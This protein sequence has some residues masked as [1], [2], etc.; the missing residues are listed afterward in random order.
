MDKKLFGLQTKFDKDGEIHL[1]RLLLTTAESKEKA[2]E[3]F[4]AYQDELMNIGGREAIDISY[5]VEIDPDD[6][7]N[8]TD[9]YFLKD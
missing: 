7:T 8:L 3:N 9:K 2:L 5:I 4:E 1:H 6:V